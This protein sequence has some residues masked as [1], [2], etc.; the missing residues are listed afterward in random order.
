[1]TLPQ[2]PN[3]RLSGKGHAMQLRSEA[4]KGMDLKSAVAGFEDSPKFR[5]VLL[6]MLHG[7]RLRCQGWQGNSGLSSRTNLG[8]LRSSIASSQPALPWPSSPC[9]EPRDQGQH[10]I[11]FGVVG[12]QINRGGHLGQCASKHDD[13]IARRR[14]L[15]P[16]MRRSIRGNA[17]AKTQRGTRLRHL[18]KVPFRYVGM[19]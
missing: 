4:G 9:D 11:H 3:R 15:M 8:P 16:Q 18:P 13:A 5:Y 19:V 1:M 17:L 10:Y 7:C 6:R 14:M 12:P 2:I